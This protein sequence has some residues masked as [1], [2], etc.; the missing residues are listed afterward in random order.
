MKLLH[1]IVLL[2]LTATVH[3]QVPGI[4]NYQ[5]R[6]T[7]GGINFTGTGQFQFALVNT[8]GSATYWNNGAG[9]VSVPVSKGLYSVLLGD[10]T[11]ANMNTIP[12]TVFTN[13]DVLLRVWFNDG[14]TGL[15]Q[16][17]PD[18]RIAAVGFAMMAANIPDGTIT[19]SKLA[20]NLTVTG[21]FTS[22]CLQ[23][24][25]G[26]LIY[27]NYVYPGMYGCRL[28]TNLAHTNQCLTVA[29]FASAVV[30][31]TNINQYAPGY[32]A[33][34]ALTMPE[35][36]YG[37]TNT[38]WHNPHWMSSWSGKL[39][40]HG[41][42]NWVTEFASWQNDNSDASGPM[43]MMAL[44]AGNT[45]TYIYGSL[46]VTNKGLG[47][48]TFDGKLTGNGSGLT[49][50]NATSLRIT[51]SFPGVPSVLGSDDG[52]NFYWTPKP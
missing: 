12:I 44:D 47:S 38:G 52:I 42:D 26:F 46:T 10:A 39:S 15:Q 27:S 13:Q 14:V 49:G 11:I 37:D 2:T 1:L 4:I 28:S 48:I 17:I 50:I 3:A 51:N 30:G 45:N 34:I 20:S 22:G 43:L 19:S 21:A 29:E 7:V 31:R 18:Q 35:V 24:T 8:D 9:I 36:A 32:G 33:V 16:L 6:V 41:Y 5:G 23:G 40:P 25:S